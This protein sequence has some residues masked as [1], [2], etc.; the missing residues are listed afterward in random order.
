MKITFNPLAASLPKSRPIKTEILGEGLDSRANFTFSGK[1]ALGLLFTYYLSTGK[2]RQKTDQVLVP[3][4]MGYWV[5]MIM[6]KTCFPSQAMSPKTRGILAYHQ[7]GFPQDMDALKT[8]CHRKGLFC[9]EDCA[10]A[11][12]GYDQS[13][14]RLGTIGDA[15][16]FSLAKFFPS[17]V[18][19][20]VY[21]RHRPLNAFLS[22]ALD[23]RK[24]T[25]TDEVFRARQ[26]YDERPTEVHQ[27]EV[28]R[29]YAVYD[30]LGYCPAPALAVA[31]REIREGALERRRAILGLF[32]DAFKPFR[33]TAKLLRLEVLPWVVPVFLPETACRRIAKRLNAMGIE[34]GVYHFDVHRNMLKPS[35]K[36]CLVLP[37]HQD[38]PLRL[39][40][41]IADAVRQHA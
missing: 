18:G 28:E 37:C 5:Y 10:H 19:G 40:E 24:T 38:I 12:M 15:S 23:D 29:N 32:R 3:E 41:R 14:R 16:I 31:E 39:V 27:I 13:G 30:R 7:W 25:L 36:K 1:T 21:S 9:I 26:R 34:S 33:Q 8:F 2:L 20:A 17:V 35:Y 11:F 22:G 4:W 6:Q